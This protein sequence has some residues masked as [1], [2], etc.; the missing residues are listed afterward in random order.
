MYRHR[1]DSIQQKKFD[2]EFPEFGKELRNIRLGLAI[3]GMN[4]CLVI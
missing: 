1:V 2:D 3:D 4:I